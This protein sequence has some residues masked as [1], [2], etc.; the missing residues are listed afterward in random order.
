MAEPAL[1]FN[2]GIFCFFEFDITE[3]PRGDAKIVGKCKLCM[4]VN[5]TS[6]ISGRLH[7]TSNFVK[8]VR[9]SVIKV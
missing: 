9:V 4:K 1:W 8:H 6:E 7:V 3:K 5:K 2:N